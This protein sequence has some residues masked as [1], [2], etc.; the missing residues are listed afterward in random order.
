MRTHLNDEGPAV[1]ENDLR[2]CAH[3]MNIFWGCLQKNI[4]EHIKLVN[5]AK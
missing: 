2:F 3:T 4:S 1:L 5:E